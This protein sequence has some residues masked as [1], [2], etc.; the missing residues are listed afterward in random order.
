MKQILKIILPQ[1]N[2]SIES[3]SLILVSFCWKQNFLRI[4]NALIALKLVI[5]GVAF[6]LGHPVFVLFHLFSGKLCD[7]T[8]SYDLPFFISGA[9]LWG[10]AVLLAVVVKCSC[11]REGRVL[12]TTNNE[13][14]NASKGP[15]ELD[16]MTWTSVPVEEECKETT[17]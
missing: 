9:L 10:A 6:F 16:T 7:A 5:V 11:W 4:Y 3:K 14:I 17:I 1:K 13:S 15:R 2:G 8:G 12:S